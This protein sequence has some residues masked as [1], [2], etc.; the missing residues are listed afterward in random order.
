MLRKTK[1]WRNIHPQTVT[2]DK[3]WQ[4]AL[5]KEDPDVNVRVYD[6]NIAEG[7]TREEGNGNIAV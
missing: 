1:A 6:A 2:K 5:N 3:P 7:A 4:M